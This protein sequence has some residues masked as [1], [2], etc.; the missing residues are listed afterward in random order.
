MTKFIIQQL[1]G[2]TPYDVIMHIA[3]RNHTVLKLVHQPRLQMQ[4]RKRLKGPPNVMTQPQDKPTV[5]INK[6]KI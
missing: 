6:Y 5:Y 2:L 4:K 1:V 3:Q